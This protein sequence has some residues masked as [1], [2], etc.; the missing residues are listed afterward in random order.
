MFGIGVSWK[1]KLQSVVVLSTTEAEFMAIT[2][3]VKE[4]LWL[5]GI[6]NELE[7]EQ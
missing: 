3:A 2:D 4:G 7:I 6:L 1:S 5:K